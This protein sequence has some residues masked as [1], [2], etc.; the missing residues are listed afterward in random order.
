MSETVLITSQE[1]AGPPS[2]RRCQLLVID[3]P[4]AGR[5][6]PLGAEPVRVGTREG[7]TLRLTDPR[8]S[9]EHLE[10]RADGLDFVVKDL[11]SRN[12]TLYEGSRIREVRVQPGATFK[13]GRSFLRLQPESQPWEVAPSQ[14][15]RFGELVGE[16]LAMRELFAVLERVSP[17]DVT[18]LLQGETG[19]GKELAARSIHEASARRKG[20]FVAVDCGALPEGLVESELFGHVKGA[21]TGALAAR[22]GAFVRANGGTLFLDELAGIPPPV[23]ARL[24]RVLEERKVRPVGGDAE[25]RVDVRV[26]A[27]SRQEL[28]LAVAEGT[29]RPDLYYR[30]AVV[31]LP[32][33]PLRQR[34][35]DL[36]LL[37]AEIL[38]R[39]GLEPGPIRGPALE[40][41]SGHAWPGNVRELRNV[42]ERA[43][44]LAPGA[45]RFEE[46]RPS[47]QPVGA[48]PE[49]AVRTDLPFS[50]AK[51]ALIEHFERHYLRDVLARARGNLSE[52]ARQSG[53]D[54]KHLRALAR[55]HGLLPSSD[56]PDD[57][58]R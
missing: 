46:L 24:L 8:V 12:G 17:S 26:V 47:L 42:L 31:P 11:E 2:P 22:S 6:V 53:V 40:L 35:E 57:A 36:P 38:R 7:C 55:R 44:A 3:G 50:E 27:A 39:R 21:F 49:L 25:Q 19:T 34:R 9:G 51:Q 37:I 1:S 20:P 54:R 5:A 58:E 4:D 48:G 30:L 15:R 41:L 29:F 10:V 52:A 33:P 45:S 56:E 23:Q 18:V 16:S 14:A 28:A 32:L 13:L 43:L